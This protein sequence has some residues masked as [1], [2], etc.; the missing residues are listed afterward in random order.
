MAH[1][2][3]SSITNDLINTPLRD[4]KGSSKVVSEFAALEP[5]IS[6][7]SVTVDNVADKLSA[8]K[9]DAASWDS[10]KSSANALIRKLDNALEIFVN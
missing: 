5:S 2:S 9:R 10:S 1:K 3:A 6:S 8:L 7:T 4:S